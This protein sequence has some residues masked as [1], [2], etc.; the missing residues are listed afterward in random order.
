MQVAEGL[1]VAQGG[2]PIPVEDYAYD[3]EGNRG[4]YT[5]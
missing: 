4:S 5:E 1:P 3:E 2:T